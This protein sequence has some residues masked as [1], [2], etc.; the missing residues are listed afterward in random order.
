MGTILIV[1]GLVP[2]LLE[3]WADA[4]SNF[5][6]MLFYRFPVS[7]RTRAP[8]QQQRRLAALGMAL[9]ALSSYAYIAR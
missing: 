8:F 6:G 5:A 1:V 2:G 7:F 4:M 3:R 9:I